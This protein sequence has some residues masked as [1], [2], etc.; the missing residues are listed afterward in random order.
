LVSNVEE[1]NPEGD[2]KEEGHLDCKG[3]VVGG[4]EEQVLDNKNKTINMT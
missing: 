1:G 2:T 3:P 4:R